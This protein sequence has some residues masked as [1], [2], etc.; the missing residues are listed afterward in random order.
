MKKKRAKGKARRAGPRSSSAARRDTTQ[1]G[2]H[3]K[4]ARRLV[5]KLG[6]KVARLTGKS[7]RRKP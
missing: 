7:R 4:I 3:V 5:K 1:F 2:E 6:R